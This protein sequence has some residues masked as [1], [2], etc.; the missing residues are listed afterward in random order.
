MYLEMFYQLCKAQQQTF[1]HPYNHEI[2]M[3]TGLPQLLLCFKVTPVYLLFN[4]FDSY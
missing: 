3:T 2:L 4:D 1:K